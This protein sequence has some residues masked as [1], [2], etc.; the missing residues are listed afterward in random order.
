MTLRERTWQILDVARPGD[1]SSR[2]F[3]L[4]ILS[5]IFTNVAA[6][7][8]GTVEPIYA[9]WAKL[10]DGFELFSVIVFTAEY[11]ARVWSCT[12]NDRYRGRLAARLRFVRQ[13]LPVIDLISFLPFYLP[14]LGVDLRFVRIFR[15]VRILRMAK[16]G[17]YYSSLTLIRDTVRARK[18]ELVLCFAILLTLLLLSATGVYYCEND[19]QP[20]AFPSIP[21]SLWW[22]VVT[23]TTVGYGDTYPVTGAGKFFAS[24]VAILGIGMFALPTGILGAGFVEEI[25]KLRATPGP[26]RCPHC[27]EPL[28]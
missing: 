15:V 28:E 6:V 5:L 10:L 22:S 25:R 21:S 1:T 3:D 9:K 27:G 20:D 24:I 14:F 8:V 16:L 2:V 12:S 26:R 17:R 11:A 4:F 23:L 19:A 13:P 7:I 18:E